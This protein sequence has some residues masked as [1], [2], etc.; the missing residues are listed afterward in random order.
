MNAV[1]VHGDV[2]V[3]DVAVG[4]SPTVGNAVTDHFID[5]RAQRLGEPAIVERAG[6]T[7]AG[8]RGL[9]AD[10]VEL[11]GGDANLNCGAHLVE[12]LGG[13]PAATRMRSI[14]SGVRTA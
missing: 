14:S 7:V 5:R 1:V 10:A 3:D 4:Q 2:H 9:V 13:Q 11:V 12:H 8:D 6:V